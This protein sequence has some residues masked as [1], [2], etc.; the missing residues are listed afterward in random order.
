VG[1][2]EKTLFLHPG[3]GALSSDLELGVRGVCETWQAP[4]RDRA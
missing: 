4:A 2:V 1:E 3:T